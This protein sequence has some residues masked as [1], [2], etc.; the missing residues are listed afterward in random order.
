MTPGKMF[1]ANA[2][3]QRLAAAQ[4]S[5]PSR[6]EMRER[7][8]LAWDQMADSAEDTAAKATANAAAKDGGERPQ[9]GSRVDKQTSGLN[10]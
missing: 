7:S 5:L 6:R 1:R 4:T 2:E 10:V 3:A 8:A 9:S